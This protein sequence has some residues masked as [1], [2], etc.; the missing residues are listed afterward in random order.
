MTDLYIYENDCVSKEELS[1]KL[2]EEAKKMFSS[3][4]IGYDRRSGSDRR[5][6]Y[7]LGYFI[8]GG[9]ERRKIPDR[10]KSHYDFREAQDDLHHYS[11]L[12]SKGITLISRF[13]TKINS[14]L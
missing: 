4:S 3:D 11:Q 7:K 14:L 2:K 6:V 5:R 8:N 9:V 13:W 10:R 12:K 1:Q